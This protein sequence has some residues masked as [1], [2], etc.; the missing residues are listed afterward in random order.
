MVDSPGEIPQPTPLDDFSEPDVPEEMRPRPPS[1]IRVVQTTVT[2]HPEVAVLYKRT[3]VFEHQRPCRLS[4]EQRPLVE[5]LVEYDE[6]GEVKA[7]AD[8]EGSDEDE[9]VSYR[10]LPDLIGYKPGTDVVVHGNALP[11][12]PVPRMSVSV[13]VDDHPQHAARVFGRRLCTNRSG[14]VRFTDPEPF[15]EMPLRYEN[16]YGGKDRHFES[17]LVENIEEQVAPEDLRRSRAVA[18]ELVSEGH[19]LMYPRNRFGKGYVIEDDPEAIEGR[20]LPNVERPSDLLTPERLVVGNPF[21]WNKQPL[22]AGFGYLDASSF[23]R[24]SM[25][26][27]PPAT[28]EDPGPFVEVERGLVPPD[29]SRGNVFNTPPEKL[30]ELIHPWAGRCASPGLTLPFLQGDEW[31]QL[32]GFDRVTSPLQFQLPG[33]VPRFRIS[34][35]RSQTWQP[36]AQLYLADVDVPA[37]TLTLV[38][39]GR[40][41]LDSPCT[42]ERLRELE[43]GVGIEMTRI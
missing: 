8:E 39:A 22:P 21:D 25:F 10:K 4:D 12:R 16:A 17:A 27:L 43:A 30:G 34:A 42:P 37:R 40:V 5:E 29:F 6:D 20:E 9:P 35:S 23:P 33:E 1:P 11:P 36:V 2:G 13:Q 28:I 15:E 41:R 31:I 26:G 18:E 19:P 32:T 24:C 38:W 3:Y 7:D 14:R